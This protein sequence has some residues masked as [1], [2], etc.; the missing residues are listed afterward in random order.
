[1]PDQSAKKRPLASQTTTSTSNAK[2]VCIESNNGVSLNL[3]NLN[4]I[5]TPNPPKTGVTLNS[6]QKNGVSL[7]LST[8]IPNENDDDD[9]TQNES[10]PT[11]IEVLKRKKN[12]K[13]TT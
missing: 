8:V 1:M 7:N 12:G 11:L 5:R 10:R 2:R 6:G 9:G 4:P 13:S 3:S